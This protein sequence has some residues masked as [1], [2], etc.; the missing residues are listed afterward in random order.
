MKKISAYGCSFVQGTGLDPNNSLAIHPHAWPFLVGKNLQFKS[1][2]NRAQGGGS[3]KFSIIRLLTD[4]ASEDFSNTLVI[5]SWTSIFRT[6]YFNNNIHDWEP[7]M[8][9]NHFDDKELR[10]AYEHYYSTIFTEYEAIYDTLQQQLFVQSFLKE[11]KIEHIFVNGIPIEKSY[12]DQQFLCSLE[13]MIDKNNYAL[14]YDDSIQD[15]ISRNN[16]KCYD[17]YHPNELGHFHIAK[18]ITEFIRTKYA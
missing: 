16:F 3:N 13:N 7:I 8:I 9:N 17:N 11:R 4:V 15:N 2:S 18:L 14:G 10:L 1:V 12:K 6:A 5:F